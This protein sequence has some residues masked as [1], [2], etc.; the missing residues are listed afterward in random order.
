MAWQTDGRT[1]L[2][3][4]SQEGHVECVRALLDGRAAINQAAVGSTI[5]MARRRVGLCVGVSMAACVHACMCI[6]SS[7][8]GCPA[9]VGLGGVTVEPMSYFRSWGASR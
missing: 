6:L 1:P 3:V 8:L 4:A 5:S 2:L 7:A 9:V